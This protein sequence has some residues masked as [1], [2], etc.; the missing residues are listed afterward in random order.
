MEFHLINGG[1]AIH[2]KPEDTARWSATG[3]WPYS[4]LCGRSVFVKVVDGHVVH[5]ECYPD[6]GDLEDAEVAAFM[7]WALAEKRS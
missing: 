5:L 6:P 3:A 4:G 7:D 2:A 1:W